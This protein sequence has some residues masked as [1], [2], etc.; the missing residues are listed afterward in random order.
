MVRSI[1][2]DT[3]E[4]VDTP[5]YQLRGARERHDALP[6]LAF[7]GGTCAL[8]CHAEIERTSKEHASKNSSRQP[9]DLVRC[10]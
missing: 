10:R 4:G 9:T 5:F 8:A 7:S 6:W 2:R 3:I 1:N